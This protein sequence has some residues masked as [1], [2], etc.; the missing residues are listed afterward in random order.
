MD[1][2][3]EVALL[4]W[5]LEE[6]ACAAHYF[7]HGSVWLRQL[8]AATSKK[9][10]V[11]ESRKADEAKRPKEM[12]DDERAKRDQYFDTLLANEHVLISRRLLAEVCN[13]G[14]PSV[15]YRSSRSEYKG[16]NSSRSE[17]KGSK[18]EGSNRVG[19]LLTH[20]QSSTMTLRADYNEKKNTI[21]FSIGPPFFLSL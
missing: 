13:A 17:L 10:A 7:T 11:V 20:S 9:T 8:R 4:N 1:S 6:Q 16:S 3:P 5:T 18:S 2:L 21:A 12:V 19:E 14:D 15:K